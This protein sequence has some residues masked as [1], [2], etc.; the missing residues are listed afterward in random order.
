MTR[1]MGVGRQQHIDFTIAVAVDADDVVPE[2]VDT[3]V[4]SDADANIVVAVDV[5]DV[6]VAVDGCGC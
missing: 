3:D 4:D 5:D 2:A 6:V 1:V